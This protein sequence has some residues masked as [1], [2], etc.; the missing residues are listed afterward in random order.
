VFELGDLEAMEV[1]AI[2]TGTSFNIFFEQPAC[3]LFYERRKLRIDT[4]IAYRRATFSII[5]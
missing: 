5:T 4:E 2:L 3:A 1:T